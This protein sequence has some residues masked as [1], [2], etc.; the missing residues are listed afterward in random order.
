MLIINFWLQIQ[1]CFRAEISSYPNSLLSDQS[2]C[3]F[4]NK[5]GYTHE[6][7]S[8]SFCI[9]MNLIYSDLVELYLIMNYFNQLCT[10]FSEDYFRPLRKSNS[11]LFNSFNN[12][13]QEIEFAFVRFSCTYASSIFY[14]SLKLQKVNPE[15]WNLP[16]SNP[17]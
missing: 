13:C 1:C 16:A 9:I 2:T 11:Y 17:L 7:C 8:A 3:V 4:I 12:R 14:T 5:A 6:I 10:E 15:R